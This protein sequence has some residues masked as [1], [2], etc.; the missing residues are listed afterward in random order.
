LATTILE[1]LGKPTGAPAL[2]SFYREFF[3]DSVLRDF[4]GDS[5]YAN[6]GYWDEATPNAASAG[7]ALIDR[8]L[9]LMP[10]ELGPVLDVACGEGGSTRRLAH[11]LAPSSITAIGVSPEQLAAARARAPGCRF[12]Q[13][14]ATALRFPPASFD[15]VLCVEAAFH[16]G[17]RERFLRQAFRVLRPGGRLLL[18]DLLLNRGSPLMPPE[19]HLSGVDA[20]AALLERCGFVDLVLRDVTRDTWHAYRRRLTR[21][22][23][24]NASRYRPRLVWR[25][26]FAANVAC[27][28]SIRASLLIAARKP[29][30]TQEAIASR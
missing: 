21:F 15:S 10:G 5:G 26:L 17:S 6:L 24:E 20:Y 30:G 2:R 27:A 29:G 19:N 22:I 1:A 18:S 9:G 7:D 14:D 8:L 11:T 28:W 25:D 12:L 3:S 23:A 4:Y 13:M 16:F